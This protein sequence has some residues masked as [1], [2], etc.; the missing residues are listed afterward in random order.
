MRHGRLL[1]IFVRVGITLALLFVLLLVMV[2]FL[3]DE[4]CPPAN[5][6]LEW[7]SCIAR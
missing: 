7:D 1:A 2:F 6:N 3:S 5:T 4:T